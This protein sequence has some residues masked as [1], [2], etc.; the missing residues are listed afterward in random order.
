MKL[1]TESLGGNLFDAAH[2]INDPKFWITWED[3]VTM[4][5]GS[6][7]TI[8]VFKVSDEEYARLKG[9]QDARNSRVAS[10]GLC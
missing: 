4:S 8:V 6:R 5:F 1:W 7:Y 3:V 9:E 2:K 10:G